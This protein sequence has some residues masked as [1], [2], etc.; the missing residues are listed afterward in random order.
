MEIR[1]I[2]VTD[3][4][5]R[6]VGKATL[7]DTPHGVVAHIDFVQSYGHELLHAGLVGYFSEMSFG[8]VLTPAVPAFPEGVTLVNPVDFTTK[9]PPEQNSGKEE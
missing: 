6:V 5:G 1:H 7:E 2:P 8:P 3:P 9:N 4:M